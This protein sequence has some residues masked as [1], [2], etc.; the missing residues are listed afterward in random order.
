MV[1]GL[2]QKGRRIWLRKKEKAHKA[3]SIGGVARLPQGLIVARGAVQTLAD[4]S[5]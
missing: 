4:N 5:D 2:Y 1:V 3:G